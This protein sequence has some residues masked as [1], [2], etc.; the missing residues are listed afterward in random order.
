[1]SSKKQLRSFSQCNEEIG[2]EQIQC[3]QRV[4]AAVEFIDDIDLLDGLT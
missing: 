2:F 4:Q 3:Q 1:M